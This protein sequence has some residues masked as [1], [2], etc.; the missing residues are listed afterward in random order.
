MRKARMDE[1]LLVRRLNP[2]PMV[3]PFIRRLADDG[4]DV[5]GVGAVGVAKERRA[6]GVFTTWPTSDKTSE[7]P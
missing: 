2:K 3:L 4:W 6:D 1:R 7:W 5:L